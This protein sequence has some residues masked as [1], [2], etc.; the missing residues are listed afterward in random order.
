MNGYVGVVIPVLQDGV[1]MVL[2][3]SW[4]DESS[5][6]ESLA[7]RIWNGDGAVRLL[8]EDPTKA[9]MLLERLDPTRTLMAVP[10]REALQTA[11]TLLRRLAIPASQD[12]RRVSDE[13]STLREQLPAL[14]KSAGCP[15]PQ[16]LLDLVLEVL[17][18]AK[19]ENALLVINWH[20]RVFNE[21]EFPGYL[22]E[23]INIIKAC[24]GCK[25][26]KL[27]QV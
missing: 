4:I 21:Q 24:K 9:A 8:D 15:F 11:G 5:A 10:I 27:E 14:W 6:Q 13:A 20:Q 17:E 1:E 16:G 12:F 25:F 2:K 19:R 3:V 22:R 7:L 18:Q 23:Y 26:L